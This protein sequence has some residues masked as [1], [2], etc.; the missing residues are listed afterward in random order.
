VAVVGTG[1]SGLSAAWLLSQS[2]D[3]TV[4]EQA[5][6]LGGHSNTIEVPGAGPV[7]MGFI[8]YNPATYPNL[9]AL[10][11]HLGVPTRASDMSFAV[12]RG[13]GALEYAGTGLNGLFAQRR[14]LLNPRF[15]A[16]LR[17]LVRFYRQAN[18]EAQAG[19]P[20]DRSL[21]DYLAANRYGEA[22]LQDHL[23]PMAAAIWSTPASLMAD[24]PAAAFLR[25]CR[26]HGLLQLTD[27]PAWRTV[28]GGSREYVRR[29]TAPYAE[30]LRLGCGVRSIRRESGGVRIL[31]TSGAE[32]VYDQ[33]VIAAHADQALRLLADPSVPEQE[34]LGA[35]RYRANDA[36]MH[37]DARLMP[38]RRAVWSSWNYMSVQTGPA[39]PPF[40]SYWMNRLQ[41]L[42]DP[43]PVF[44][45]LN[46]PES[47]APAGVIHRES[48]D[49][50][51]FDTAAMAAQRRLWSI[52]GVQRT[53]YCGA[54][55]GAGFHEDGLQAGLAVAEALGGMRRPWTVPDESGRICLGAPA[56]SV[57]V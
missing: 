12:S 27:R 19:L 13:A 17:D 36:I 41:A 3:I 39:A 14:N 20:D 18:R 2:C 8:V 24:Y 55:F 54:Y 33:V 44:V 10:F 30:R 26:N 46:T 42:A 57:A 25:F 23:L 38:R 32:A 34:L 35:L 15:W 4:Y 6:R 16:M 31:D 7:D 45:T 52:Q 21:G 43:A 11:E 5:K 37:R 40:V 48:Y 22:F 56:G 53:W 29:L 49:H 1:I 28:T 51:Q 50:P 9:T 47:C